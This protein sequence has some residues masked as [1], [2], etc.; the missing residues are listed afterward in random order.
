MKSILVLCAL[1][2]SVSAYSIGP[3]KAP[4][5]FEVIP[6]GEDVDVADYSDFYFVLETRTPMSELVVTVEN[7]GGFE[8]EVNLSQA[9]RSTVLVEVSWFPGGD[10]SGCEIGIKTKDGVSLGSSNI[11]MIAD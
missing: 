6:W 11:Y 1:L 8:C 2:F 9:D 3:I 5:H 7:F 10:S 4:V